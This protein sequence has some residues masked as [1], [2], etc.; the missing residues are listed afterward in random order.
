MSTRTKIWKTGIFGL[1]LLPTDC[2]KLDGPYD[3]LDAGGG[4]DAATSTGGESI[5]L[6]STGGRPNAGGAGGAL[7]SS[8][9]DPKGFDGRG[10]FSCT[11]VDIS[12][13]ESACTNLSCTLFDNGARLTRLLPNGQLPALPSNIVASGGSASAG[14]TAAMVGPISSGGA[15]A[16]GEIGPSG[17][18][19]AGA[20]VGTGGMVN[21][22][23]APTA[24]LGCEALGS[25]GTLVYVT[26]SSAAKPF[27]Q[28]IAQQLSGLGV[29]VVYTSTG[30]CVGV[31][32]IFNNTPMTTG[33]SPAPAV[34]ATYW[35]SSSS[36]GSACDLPITGVAADLGI[37]DVFAQTC[38][39]FEL[40]S[41]ESKQVREAHGP[42]QTMAFV[43]PANSSY[44]E[45]SAQAAYFVFGFG[46]D[47]GVLD[48]T[49]ARYL[50]D[51]E[52][53]LFQR[54]AS[55]GTQ[56]MIS[57]AIGVPA[58]LWRGKVH[59]ASGDVAADLQSVGATQDS[60]DRAIGIL[61][62]DYIDSK[63]LR[64]QIRMLAYQDSNQPCAFYPDS[65]P[66]AR[67]KRNV[68]DGH[69]P[70]WSPLHILYKVDSSGNPANS[71]NQQETIDIIGYLAGS[72][73]LPNGIKLIDV[74]AQSGLIP[75][76]AMRVTRQKD[77][78][79]IL[80]FHP[81]NPCSCLFEL[82][83]TGSTSC[84]ACTVQGDCAQ[85]ETCSL[86]FCEK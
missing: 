3:R 15:T 58:A 22:G 43:V 29:Y 80:P 72:K 2:S 33:P 14:T 18:V 59:S 53:Y 65:T 20:T 54:N 52:N 47:G 70:I 50:W 25:K 31:D 48:S 38:P 37:S 71:A 75:E 86:G 63:N 1:L 82:T 77:G 83:A 39:G 84:S 49:A 79:N 74:Y 66:T 44:A 11:P 45:I 7:G 34:S 5:E 67:D 61:A 62:A 23:G 56:A 32:A 36:N 68:R 19:S 57:A 64:A 60:A 6:T 41:L 9:I 17:G 24:N 27:L 78:G 76:C 30:S 73:V 28:Q 10:C 85:S 51:D 69:Y 8:C 46:K 4:A 40:A 35:E 21:T 42:I 81:T 13:L 26:G 55:S 16:T 12:T